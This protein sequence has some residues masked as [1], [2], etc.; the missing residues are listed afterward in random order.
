MDESENLAVGLAVAAYLSTAHHMRESWLLEECEI[1]TAKLAY[2]LNKIR[3]EPG[4][5]TRADVRI[6][7]ILSKLAQ[8][9]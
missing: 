9:G 2:S 7:R 6:S 5:W 8:R 4:Q 1:E 3:F